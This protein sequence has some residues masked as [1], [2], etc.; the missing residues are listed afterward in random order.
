MSHAKHLLVI[1]LLLMSPL[2][3]ISSSFQELH[4]HELVSTNDED[5]TSHIIKQ[6]LR[7]GKGAVPDLVMQLLAGSIALNFFY[8]NGSPVEKQRLI[9]QLQP[10]A[11]AK[12]FGQEYS[13]R[14]L[15]TL[16]HELGHAYT[17]HLINGDPINIHLGATTPPK[18]SKPLFSSTHFT[19]EGLHPS[20][21]FCLYSTPRDK[22]KQ[23]G[24]AGIVEK[25]SPELMYVGMVV[26]QYCKKQNIDISSISKQSSFQEFFQK[27]YSSLS[28]AEKEAIEKIMPRNK[29]K[30][31][32]ILLAGG[33]TGLASNAL[34]N[35][36]LCTIN[37]NYPSWAHFVQAAIKLDSRTANQLL[38]LLIPF[39]G[40]G[41]SDAFKLYN[42][43][44]GI[45]QEPLKIIEHLAPFIDL[46]LE[47]YITSTDPQNRRLSLDKVII[48][49][50]ANVALRGFF[51]FHG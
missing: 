33:M 31:A 51:R 46:L 2:Q 20:K 4:D 26:S 28:E 44:L 42:E 38:N 22:K 19:L 7:G 14:L 30:Q 3:A 13:L 34:I 18:D 36:I 27:A 8:W 37:D 40:N 1:F 9:E 21:G 15:V 43:C 50:S 17:A 16:L 32:A 39:G 12:N 10:I 24:L 29:K 35:G 11:L 25:I 23:D 49:T 45:P 5:S 48:L 47:F 41:S 6:L